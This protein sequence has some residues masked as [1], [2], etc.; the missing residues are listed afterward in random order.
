MI[1]FLK[2]TVTQINIETQQGK[3][4]VVRAQQVPASAAPE[5]GRKHSPKDVDAVTGGTQGIS[6]YFASQVQMQPVLPDTDDT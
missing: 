6:R 4:P 3:A 2:N 1:V 5:Q